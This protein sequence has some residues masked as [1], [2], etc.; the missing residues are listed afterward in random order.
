METKKSKSKKAKRTAI[1]DGG[2]SDDDMADAT[3]A[4]Y[5]A[6][7]SPWICPSAISAT[8]AA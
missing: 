1:V 7:F 3:P 2:D 4:K 5:V 8:V 6:H